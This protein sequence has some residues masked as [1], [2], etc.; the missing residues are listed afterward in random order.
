[1]LP[2]VALRFRWAAAAAALLLP[3]AAAAEQQG[4][5]FDCA[6]AATPIERQVCDDW[7]LSA[8]DL[9]MSQIYKGLRDGLDA[10]G[11]ER[12]KQE[13]IAW[14]KNERDACATAEA[15][16]GSG[17]NGPAI[18]SC[19]YGVYETR[20]I[21]LAQELE[22]TL[23]P[24]QPEGPWSGSYAMDDGFTGAGVVLLQMPEGTVSLQLSAV[25]G[26]TYHICELTAPGAQRGPDL[27]QYRDAEEP[28][29]QITFARIGDGQGT[30]KVTS[31][32]CQ[33]Y[34][35]ARAYFDGLYTAV[36]PGY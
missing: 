16:D 27:L 12:L 14:L 35:G 31:A 21:Q 25:S 2:R 22:A 32:G 18:W 6:K 20:A 30:I 4:P 10:A 13:Q 7:T 3:Q 34:C 33:I 1:M 28:G 17:D 24:A 36:R 9:W 19:L 26:P 23:Y 29:C 5:G 15:Q 11:R 8:Y